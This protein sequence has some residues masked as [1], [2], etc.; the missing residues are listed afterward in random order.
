MRF[1]LFALILLAGVTTRAQSGPTYRQLAVEHKG[2]IA[3][4]VGIGCGWA[5][6]PLAS[7]VRFADLALEGIVVSRRTSATPDDRDILTEYEIGIRQVIFQ[8]V[9]QTAARPGPAPPTIFKARGGTVVFDGYPFTLTGEPRTQLTVGNHVI[10]FGR[11]D[12][13]DGKWLFGDRGVFHVSE[14]LVLNWLPTLEVSEGLEPRMALAA[15]AQ[16]V[17]ALSQ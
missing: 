7:I 6:P 14:N 1:A 3:A 13:S 10:L 8:R 2:Q 9:T 15:F 16:K 4:T 17:R 11:Y 12:K 5:G